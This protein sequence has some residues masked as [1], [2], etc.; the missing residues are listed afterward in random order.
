MQLI[1]AFLRE[2]LVDASDRTREVTFALSLSLDSAPL[3]DAAVDSGTQYPI[4]PSSPAERGLYNR[5]R[6]KRGFPGK[7][8]RHHNITASI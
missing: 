6:R 8:Q 4:L 7:S 3:A 1:K 2:G 5:S